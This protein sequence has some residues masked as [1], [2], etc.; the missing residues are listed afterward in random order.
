MLGNMQD[1]QMSEALAA[2]FAAFRRF[3]TKRSWQQQHEPI[4][5]V[6]TEKYVDHLRY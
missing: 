6:T 5:E 4:T 2:D 1:D 3:C